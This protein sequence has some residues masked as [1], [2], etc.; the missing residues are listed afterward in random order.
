MLLNTI[1]KLYPLYIP[2]SYCYLHPMPSSLQALANRSELAPELCDALLVQINPLDPKR[3]A[4]GP[5]A[6][7]AKSS[8]FTIPDAATWALGVVLR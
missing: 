4:K 2:S 7:A 1:L 3:A 5:S 8:D 6:A